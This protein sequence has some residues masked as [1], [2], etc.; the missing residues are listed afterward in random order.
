MPR[1][2]RHR[3]D[4]GKLHSRPQRTQA[5]LQRAVQR[6]R[7]RRRQAR[8]QAD[9]LYDPAQQLS[10]RNLRRAAD[11]LTALEFNPQ[12]RA[13][14]RE[15]AQVET[16]GGALQSRAGDYFRQLAERERGSVERARAL[17]AQLGQDVARIG[18]EAQT[19]LSDVGDQALELMRQDEAVRGGGLSGGTGAVGEELAAARA[20]AT[21]T[22][23]TAANDAAAQGTGYAQLADLSRQARELMGGEIVGQLGNR[24]AGQLE[25]V[26][27]RMAALEELA[28][29]KRTQN[30]LTLRQQ[31]FENAAT[32]A[33]LDLDREELQAQMQQDAAETRLARQRLR[34]TNRQNRQRNRLTER[35][36]EATERG[37]DISAETQRRGQDVSAEQRRLDRESRERIARARRTGSKLESADA[38]KVKTGI[39]N[40][41]AD[42]ESVNPKRPAK[43][44]RKQG[45]PGIVIRA[46][47]ERRSGGLK[48]STVAELRRLGI[49]VP[50]SW[51]GNY[52][53]PPTPP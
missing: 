15:A 21:A 20:R 49:R 53:G 12:R 33:G 39:V 23:Q 7:R 42:L 47:L 18:G 2:K 28:G 35:Q 4:D 37:Q 46:A 1:A 3:W 30:L 26:R 22:Q 5:Q 44:L 32:A 43:W 16:Q 19:Q 25:D 24:T 45:A 11:A 36:I 50:R 10:G 38:K 6:K 48:L 9:P 40:A 29:P 31:G 27:G 41:V 51:I 8:Q 14:Q 17:G 34:S 52:A 13:L